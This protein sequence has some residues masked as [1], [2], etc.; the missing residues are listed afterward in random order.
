[1]NNKLSYSLVIAA[2]FLLGPILLS[3]Q[4]DNKEVAQSEPPALHSEE[5]TKV[6]M[7]SQLK[8]SNRLFATGEVLLWK[9]QQDDLG[10]AVKSK[11]TTSIQ[12]GKTKDPKF[13]WNWGFRVG[14]GYNIPHDNWDLAGSYTQFQTSTH[15][16][17][18]ANGGDALF[19]TWKY[20]GSGYAT[21]ATAHW[22][23]HLQLGDL[24]LGRAIGVAKW[25]SIRPHIGIRAAWIYQ[26][27]DITYSGGTTV[28][29]GDTDEVSLRNNFWGIGARFGADSLWGLGKGFSM[30][31]DGAFSLLSGFFHVHQ[32]E[33]LEN[34]GTTYI[35]V[36]SHPNTVVTILDLAMGFQ[37]DT[38]FSHKKYHLGV[39]LGYE[40]NYLF[41]QNQ[42]MRFISGS[43]GNFSTSNGDL[44][45][46]GVTLGLRFDF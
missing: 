36:T 27:Y 26:K 33:H 7:A 11:S 43:P 24:E 29:A 22:R 1:M 12:K 40:F 34:G 30:F 6:F 10:F 21:E 37:Y 23:L 41:D 15:T 46:M 17:D 8:N 5:M 38:F 3:A 9:A 45:L 28:P 35:N 32:N 16:V 13:N 31:T 14:F 20:D 4:E 2:P 19:P 44:S 18:T 42:F 25:L 39:K